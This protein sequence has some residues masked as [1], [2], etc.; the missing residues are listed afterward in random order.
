[1]ILLK[2][3]W[4]GLWRIALAGGFLLEFSRS[5]RLYLMRRGLYWVSSQSLLSSV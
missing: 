3:F 2:W 4:A 1:M 5:Q